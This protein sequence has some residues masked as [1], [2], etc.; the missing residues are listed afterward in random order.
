[1]S[2]FLRHSNGL[3]TIVVC[4]LLM[5]FSLQLGAIQRQESGALIAMRF[6]PQEPLNGLVA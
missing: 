6:L 3:E 2:G 1:L 4:S 5:D